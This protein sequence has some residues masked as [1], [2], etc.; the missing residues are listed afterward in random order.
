VNY[1]ENPGP[2]SAPD[3]IT[4]KTPKGLRRAMLRNNLKQKGFV[5]YEFIQYVQSDKLWY[6]WFYVKPKTIREVEGEL[7]GDI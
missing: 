2:L 7:S 5:V 4:A 1:I 6:A 3:F